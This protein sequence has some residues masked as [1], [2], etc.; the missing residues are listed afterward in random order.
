MDIDEKP[1]A[2]S[3]KDLAGIRPGSISIKP[4]PNAT[5]TDRMPVPLITPLQDDPIHQV[6][7]VISES[8]V[9]AEIEEAKVIVG[10]S[11]NQFGLIHRTVNNFKWN[12]LVW[13]GTTM[14]NMGVYAS[15]DDAQVACSSAVRLVESI[16]TRCG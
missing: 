12:A 2:D 5:P 14:H 6:P 8:V 4:D 3:S 16:M 9:G 1:L 13:D 10:S 15:E 7:S 11:R